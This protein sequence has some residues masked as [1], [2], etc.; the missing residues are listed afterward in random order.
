MNI[1]VSS[2]CRVLY[3]RPTCLQSPNELLKLLLFFFFYWSSIRFNYNGYERKV[4]L[5]FIFNLHFF[6]LNIF[7]K[8]AY[9][10]Q[11]FFKCITLLIFSAW[12][13]G[14]A[15]WSFVNCFLCSR[16]HMWRQF[17]K[18]CL[19]VIFVPNMVHILKDNLL[20]L[21]FLWSSSS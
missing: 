1:I 17:V 19:I 20:R 21:L 8:L 3:L 6:F 9:I 16:F 5:H 13:P 12:H 7:Y 18:T 4:W 10:N 15:K 2:Y 14:I 11:F